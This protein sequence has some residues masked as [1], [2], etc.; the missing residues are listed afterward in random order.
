[1]CIGV[2][3]CI[4]TIDPDH[5]NQ[6]EA[7][8]NGIICNID[9][10]LISHEQDQSLIGQWVLVHTG[11]A[12]SKLDEEE[13]QNTLLMLNAMQEEEADVAVLFQAQDRF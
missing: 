6:A 4:K 5:P 8:V 11:F 9:I 12:M 1:M 7:E 2:P 3:C 10:S 13:A